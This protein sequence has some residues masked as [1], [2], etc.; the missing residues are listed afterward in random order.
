[1]PSG[2][3]S[4]ANAFVSNPTRPAGNFAPAGKP[5]EPFSTSTRSNSV[6]LTKEQI[7]SAVLVD[8]AID[9]NAAAETDLITLTQASKLIRGKSGGFIN[10]QV[11]QRYCR[12]GRV[13]TVAG[14]LKRLVLPATIRGST[15]Y[16]TAAAVQAFNRKYGELAAAESGSLVAPNGA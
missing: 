8:L 9:V 14:Q 4:P 2:T 11:L 16:T 10:L 13:F 3:V 6:P 5:R 1:L 7:A 12:R 15:R